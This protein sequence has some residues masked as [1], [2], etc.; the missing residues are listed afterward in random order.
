[1]TTRAPAVLKTYVGVTF[2]T[3]LTHDVEG[4]GGA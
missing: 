4:G 3:G 1:M 2:F